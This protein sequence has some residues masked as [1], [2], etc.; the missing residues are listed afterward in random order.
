MCS[1][2]EGNKNRAVTSPGDMALTDEAN[3]ADSR[4]RTKAESLFL[5][6]GV[7]PQATSTGHFLAA[8]N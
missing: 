8:G 3:K 6:Q 7:Q 4:R 1:D 2:Q 5:G